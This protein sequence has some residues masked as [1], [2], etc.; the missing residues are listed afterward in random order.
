ME[1]YFCVFSVTVTNREIIDVTF[2]TPERLKLEIIT[3]W[4]L[5]N[6]CKMQ[7]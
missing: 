2:Q 6:V 5:V 3:K 7:Q 4:R 1:C